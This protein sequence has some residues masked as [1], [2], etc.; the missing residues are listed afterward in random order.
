MTHNESLVNAAK[1]QDLYDLQNHIAWTDVLRPRLEEQVTA[2][3]GQ[4]VSEALGGKIPGGKT[5]EQI[6]G[7]AYGIRFMITLMERILRD[8]VRAVDALQ[9]EGLNLKDDTEYGR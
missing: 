4:L 6:A 8:G 7:I 3:A 9:A 2:F 5:R 1:A